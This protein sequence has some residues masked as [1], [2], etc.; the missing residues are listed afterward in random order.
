[1][2]HPLTVDE[3][4]ESVRNLP[5][6]PG[7]AIRIMEAVRKDN[8]TLKEISDI[9]SVDP[10][11]SA[12]IL[13]AVNSPLYCLVRPVTSVHHAVTLLGTNVV[14]NLA[15]SF[16]I[17]Q[18]NHKS[19]GADSGFDYA[20]FWKTSIISAVTSKLMMKK[21][22]PETAEDAF[23]LGL[24]HNIGTLALQNGCPDQYALVLE[25]MRA[26]QRYCHDAEQ[27]AF[28]F[29]H[30]DVGEYLIRSWGLPERFSIPVR[31][32]HCPEGPEG[33]QSELRDLAKVLHLSSLFA[34]VFTCSGKNVHLGV[35]EYHVEKYGFFDIGCIPEITEETQ[36][37][38]ADMFPLFEIEIGSEESYIRIMEEARKE[39]VHVSEDLM[40][41]FIEQSRQMETLREKALRDHLTGLYNHQAFQDALER[42]FHRTQ[43]YDLDLSV[44][45]LDI[46]HFKQTND[47]Y[48]HLAGDHVLN[49]VGRLLDETVRKCDIAARYGGEEFAVLLPE[50]RPDDAFRVAERIRKRIQTLLI[51]YEG[52][53]IGVTVSAGA[54]YMEQGLDRSKTDLLQ[55]ADKALYLAKAHGR[56]RC[57]LA[58][59]SKNSEMEET[60]RAVAGRMPVP[61]VGQRG[62]S[63]KDGYAEM[64]MTSAGAGRTIQST[65]H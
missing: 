7:I 48:G 61:V 63:G 35:L 65:R 44:I 41:R 58:V 25:E 40:E 52:T 5:T 22:R 23:V 8:S 51:D 26:T 53:Y 62:Q 15:L 24:L 17:V 30:M 57:V 20:L 54:A 3:M 10:P 36:K 31:Y 33:I 14:K 56:N 21:I 29:N 37:H 12:K 47:V 4:M 11:L 13:K 59:Q 46:D 64:F 45:L 60:F 50:T 9:L 16:S 28:G 2:K 39:L 42:E 27:T 19:G 49:A 1:M 38:T 34:D 32:H 6:L 18:T 43:R 55:R